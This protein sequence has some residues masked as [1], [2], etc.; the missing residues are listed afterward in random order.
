MAD[1]DEGRLKPNKAS[2]EDEFLRHPHSGAYIRNPLLSKDMSKPLLMQ[3]PEFHHNC[4]EDALA[5]YTCITVS[6]ATLREMIAGGAGQGPTIDKGSPLQRAA[7]SQLRNVTDGFEFVIQLKKSSYVAPRSRRRREDEKKTPG[8][9]SIDKV[10]IEVTE[11]PKGYALRIEGI[12]EGLITVWNR[13]HETFVVRPGD[14]ITRVND[15]RKGPAMIE[16]L[17]QASDALR[18]TVR[19]SP[20]RLRPKISMPALADA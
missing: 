4:L 10:N 15:K 14:Y 8:A 17:E 3:A 7:L 5:E 6:E 9:V 13:T 12:N 1:E 19:R 20:D 11:D 18:V 16:E 2:P